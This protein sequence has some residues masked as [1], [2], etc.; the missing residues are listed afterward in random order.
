MCVLVIKFE[1]VD[2]GRTNTA[3]RVRGTEDDG[4]ANQDRRA[5]GAAIVER[6]MQMDRLIIPLCSWECVARRL[7]K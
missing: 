2:S 6:V 4:V 7:F 3:A 5:I 1:R